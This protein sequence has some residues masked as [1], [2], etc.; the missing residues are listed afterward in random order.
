MS[1]EGPRARWCREAK[2]AAQDKQ[3]KCAA[4]VRNAVLVAS[5]TPALQRFARAGVAAAGMSARVRLVCWA[6]GPDVLT[7]TCMTSN[8]ISVAGAM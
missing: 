3:C 8:A 2:R 1:W 5:A 7:S 6:V 4:F